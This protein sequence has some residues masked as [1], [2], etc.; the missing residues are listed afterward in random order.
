MVYLGYGYLPEKDDKYLKDLP[1]IICF[2]SSQMIETIPRATEYLDN[3]L[4]MKGRATVEMRVVVKSSVDF[5]DF[6]M[7]WNTEIDRGSD[8][9]HAQLLF[10]G[11]IDIFKC[12]FVSHLVE[13]VTDGVHWAKVKI[14]IDEFHNKLLDPSVNY[15][16][17][18]GD[19]TDCSEVLECI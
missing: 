9:F 8:W 18:C 11:I 12:R 19:L 10:F 15:V 16:L 13:E 4:I 5:H 2:A 1:N 3:R 7:W 17:V 14:E 6:A